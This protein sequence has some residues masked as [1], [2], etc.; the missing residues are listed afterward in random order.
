ML[1]KFNL[2]H[3]PKYHSRNPKY[4]GYGKVPVKTVGDKP[5]YE[6]TIEDERDFDPILELIKDKFD[7]H[8]N[9]DFNSEREGQQ[10]VE[11]WSLEMR[12]ER[13]GITHI[14]ESPI[15]RLS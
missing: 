11:F 12:W 4:K 7:T 6:V 8:W 15:E 5:Y 14:Y 10:N 2:Y 3:N 13:N 9:G 1:Y